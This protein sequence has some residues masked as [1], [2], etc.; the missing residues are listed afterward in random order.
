MNKHVYLV[1]SV[2]ELSKIFM[3]EIW[4]DYVKRKYGEKGKLCCMDTDSLI[5]YI[6][7]DDIYKDIQEDVETTFDTSNY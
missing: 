5:A 1:L 6:K 4:H 2:L 7:T 3:Y